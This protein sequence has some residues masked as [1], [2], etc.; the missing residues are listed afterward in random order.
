MTNVEVLLQKFEVLPPAQ[1]KKA[2]EYV[3][4]LQKEV[5]GQSKRKS[6]KGA[7]KHLNIKITDEDIREARNEMWRGYT[8]DTENEKQ[9]MDDIVIDTH[10]AIWYFADAS[11]LSKPAETAIDNAEANGIIFVSAITIVELIYLTEKG[12][13]PPDVLDLLRDALD[14]PTTAFRLIETSREVADEVENI[15]RQTVPEMPDRIIAATALHLNLP[16]VT[17]D[18]KIQAL[19]NIQTIWQKIFTQCCRVRRKFMR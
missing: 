15:P 19:Q 2:I 12:K 13:I 11:Q 16:L 9:F 3:D 8:K 17:K 18:H 5:S 7:L 6:L 14:D 10:I 1:Q 4:A